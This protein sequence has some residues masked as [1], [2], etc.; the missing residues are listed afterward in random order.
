[1]I[2]EMFPLLVVSSMAAG[3]LGV[4]VSSKLTA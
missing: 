1:M 3:I 4:I 2:D